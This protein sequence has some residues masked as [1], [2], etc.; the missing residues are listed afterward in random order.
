MDVS[1]A[2]SLALALA[3]NR[4]RKHLCPSASSLD[5]ITINELPSPPVD[6]ARIQKPH[7][8]MQSIYKR[9]QPVMLP[10]G[11][12]STSLGI[13]GMIAAISSNLI[14]H[15]L[16]ATLMH[17]KAFQGSRIRAAAI[18]AIVQHA[19]DFKTNP[20]TTVF[21]NNARTIIDL[22]LD[23]V[24]SLSDHIK[25]ELKAEY[26]ALLKRDPRKFA[27]TVSWLRSCLD[28]YHAP[29]ADATVRWT[30][31]LLQLLR[32]VNVA[33]GDCIRS[34]TFVS[35]KLCRRLDAKVALDHWVQHS[36]AS[37]SFPLA[38]IA[39][40]LNF[41]EDRFSVHAKPPVS[42]LEYPFILTTSF[43][44]QLLRL[45]A[46]MEMSREFQQSFYL[47]AFLLEAEKL[48]QMAEAKPESRPSKCKVD[49]IPYLLLQARRG[50]ETEDLFNL[51]AAYPQTLRK[52][53]K[54]R[55]IG[56]GE[57][58]LDMG[59]LQKELLQTVWTDI[60]D[61]SYG[62]FSEQ[63]ESRWLYFNSLD[64]RASLRHFELAGMVLGLAAYNGVL[65]DLKLPAAFYKLLLELP[66]S[67]EDYA[68]YAPT[69]AESLQQVLT[70]QGDLED[71]CQTF[72]VTEE[73]SDGMREVDLVPNG[74]SIDVTSDTKHEFVR[75]YI[76]YKLRGSCRKELAAFRQGF[77]TIAGGRII[78]MLDANELKLLLCGVSELNF[79][80]LKAGAVYEDFTPE[81]PTV[82]AFW[83][84]VLNFDE[85]QKRL[86]LA[87]V[88]GSDRE[89]ISGLASIKM[90]IQRNGGDSERLPTSLTC[91]SR[92]LLPE[93]STKD[94]LEDRLKIAI[95][96]TK[97]FGLV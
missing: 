62:L 59:G 27:D 47:Q 44:R 82:Q 94:L 72:S 42:F 97:G 56:S 53:L 64:T 54:V 25:K 5:A 10:E 29:Y 37:R 65:L 41:L 36:E 57:Q 34:T 78:S 77:L 61:P 21:K 87:F 40:R 15:G 55:Y 88:T 12:I 93:Y 38:T 7:K 1:F 60:S 73:H 39:P 89:P 45:E 28:E 83:D 84:V 66:V 33:Q 92:L 2:H 68:D 6:F 86:F 30:L 13:K 35:T 63:P 48:F 19:V 50:F 18:L 17:L 3:A 79:L 49:G 69:Q 74:A 91:F 51:L 90:C 85:K 24:Y 23:I 22:A 14:K 32:D 58:G 67:L 52:P 43:K 75:Y 4:G 71:L 80:Q 26:S 8:S 96:N 20:Q 70:Y 16:P 31:Q 95:E 46:A 9:L 76:D 81:H 11:R